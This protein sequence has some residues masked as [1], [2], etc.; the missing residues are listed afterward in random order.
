M[1]KRIKIENFKALQEVD[2]T[3]KKLNI[4]T[5]L[6]GMGKSTI[7]QSLLLLRQSFQPPFDTL[8]LNNHLIELGTFREI[9]CE[10]PSSNQLSLM[11][12]WEEGSQLSIERTYDTSLESQKS[13]KGEALDNESLKEH[14]LF[15]EDTFKYLSAHRMKPSDVYEMNA[16]LIDKRQLGN[17]GE[18]APHYY[19]L[20][21]NENIGIKAL[22]FDEDDHIFSLEHQLNQWLGV[23]SPKIIV[24]TES[25][26]GN[27]I[28]LT[29]S[30]VTAH[31]NTSSY[32]PKNAGFGLTYVFSVLVALLTAREGD[33]LVIENP[34]SHIHPKGQTELARLMALAA[35]S[36]VQIFCETH[37]DHII[38]G[39]RIAIKEREIDKDEV[40]LYYIDRDDI[41]H[42]SVAHKIEIDKY[43]RLD[44]NA[45]KYFNEFESHLNRLM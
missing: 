44:R 25:V 23:I 40:T 6:N 29:Y 22:A 30:Y 11:L 39:T 21:K 18:F 20:N 17:E 26:N 43:G 36:G 14:A 42:F 32:L 37:S 8:Y 4:F 19:H 10:N 12:Q 15:A 16:S 5:G 24:N 34:E 45:R 33:I 3:T 13:I 28:Q 38:Y 35:K 2:L 31:G 41:E 1:I 9:F 7:L 27:M